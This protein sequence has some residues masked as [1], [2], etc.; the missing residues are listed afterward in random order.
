MQDESTTNLCQTVPLLPSNCSCTILSFLL[1]SFTEIIVIPILQYSFMSWRMCM[2]ITSQDSTF[3]VW[4]GSYSSSTKMFSKVLRRVH[5]SPWWGAPGT[6]ALTRNACKVTWCATCGTYGVLHVVH[7]V[8][9]V[10]H[11]SV[12][13]LK[14][15]AT[16]V[17]G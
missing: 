2:V 14:D 17:G 6:T 4:Q 10:C 11:T 15:S 12:F 5:A 16:G 3:S 13:P 8:S 7:V 1:S 9:M